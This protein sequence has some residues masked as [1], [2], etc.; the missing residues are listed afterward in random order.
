[1]PRSTTAALRP[2]RRSA[3]QASGSRASLGRA[4]NRWS[5]RSCTVRRARIASAAAWMSS[6][7]CGATATRI[8]RAAV[9]EFTE[10]RSSCSQR[11]RSSCEVISDAPGCRAGCASNCFAVF[12]VAAPYAPA[13]LW[14]ATTDHA[15]QSMVQCTISP[16]LVSAEL[17]S[18]SNAAAHPRDRLS[19]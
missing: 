14:R 3:L 6:P 2:C 18:R 12:L 15:A 19:A 8:V 4:G 13:R 11:W 5:A 7:A 17:G 1:M 10:S 16:V 9:A